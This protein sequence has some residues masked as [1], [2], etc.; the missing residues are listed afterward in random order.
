M[1]EFDPQNPNFGW[2][3]DPQRHVFAAQCPTFAQ[4]AP[5]CMST[6]ITGEPILLYKAWKDVLGGYPQYEAQVNGS[7]VSMGY[8]HS[9]DLLQCV[10]I[11]LG[12]ASEYR[13]THTEFIYAASREVAGILGRS[14]GSYGSAA[15]KAMKNIG[16][17]SREMLG[18]DGPYS[19]PREKDWGY[20]GPP[21][22]YKDVAA[23]YKIGEAALVRTW[24]ELEAAIKNGYPVPICSNYGFNSPR[25]AQGFCAARGTWN[26]CMLLA[27]LRYDREG[28]CCLQSWGPDQP[29]GPLALDQ[30]SYSFWIDRR[31]VEAILSQGDSF[32]L[33]K[34]PEFVK[35]ELP[36]KWSWSIA[37]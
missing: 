15:V 8:G 3:D 32:A 31:H 16:I 36:S 34:S 12:E 22:K 17:V 25:D 11:A 28:A 6:P 23:K 10:E 2:I 37:A 5:A 20:Y 27:G 26:H 4:A 33:A 30:P 21:Q 24:E 7:C 9:N 14:D 13:E 35:R 18:N 19:G 1:A 29:Q